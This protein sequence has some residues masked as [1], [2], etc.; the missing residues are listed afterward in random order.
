[1]T[2]THSQ[3]TSVVGSTE[4]SIKLTHLVQWNV[5]QLYICLA[6]FLYSFQLKSDYPQ[7]P[8]KPAEPI[9]HRHEFKNPMIE[10]MGRYDDY[11]QQLLEERKRDFQ[12][13]I[14]QV[15]LWNLIKCTRSIAINLAA[16]FMTNAR[17]NT[18]I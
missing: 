7:A 5:T 10:S 6:C 9:K 16:Q 8:V 15:V 18:I 12:K 11:R 1:M 13:H 3:Q 17:E 14:G 4:I 2:I